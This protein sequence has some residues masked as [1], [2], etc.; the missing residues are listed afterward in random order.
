MKEEFRPHW[1]DREIVRMRNRSRLV[2]AQMFLAEL[3]REQK[4]KAKLR[5]KKDE[6]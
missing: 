5:G 6:S 1:T 2:A 3:K 4:L